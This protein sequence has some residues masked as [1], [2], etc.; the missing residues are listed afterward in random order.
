MLHFAK[1]CVPGFP[2]L[3]VLVS[4]RDCGGVL[5][6]TCPPLRLFSPSVP[7]LRQLGQE[8]F[9]VY[10]DARVFRVWV[11]CL[12]R[13]GANH[14]SIICSVGAQPAFLLLRCFGHATSLRAGVESFLVAPR[15]TASSPGRMT[16]VSV[17]R[18]TFR[19]ARTCEHMQAKSIRSTHAALCASNILSTP[20]C[21]KR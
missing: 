5:L 13:K 6:T 14:M 18:P 20:G 3:W 9:L 17:P 16:C 4:M 7:I 19:R 2:S 15:V 1:Q 10:S 11:H 21:G 8:F 12:I